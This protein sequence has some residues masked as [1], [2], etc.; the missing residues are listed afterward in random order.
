MS[1]LCHEIA[2]LAFL[3]SQLTDMFVISETGWLEALA[4][5]SFNYLRS[6]SSRAKTF[7]GGL[8]GADMGYYTLNVSTI[9][10]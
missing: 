4:F 7:M 2:F 6:G 10:I 5:R 3:P 8:R 9:C 1:N